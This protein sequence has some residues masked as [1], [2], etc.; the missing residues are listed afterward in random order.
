MTIVEQLEH[1]GRQEGRQ[2]G[3]RE[4]LQEGRRT[5]AASMLARIL[6]RRFGPVPEQIQKTIE[7]AS[8]E[9]LE[10]WVDRALDAETLADV[11]PL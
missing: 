8:L 7:A 1:K 5:E 4:G 9:E 6:Q 3:R 11:F 2:E 10:N